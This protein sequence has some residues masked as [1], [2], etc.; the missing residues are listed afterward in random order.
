[1]A[2]AAEQ[3]DELRGAFGAAVVDG[4]GEGVAVERGEEGAAG[5]GDGGDEAAGR[6][7]GAGVAGG[8][9]AFD[10]VQV[11]FDAAHDG[12]EGDV[13]GGL[14][15]FEAAAAAAFEVDEAGLSEL[16]HDFAEVVGRDAK[17]GGDGFGGD[18]FVGECGEV[19]QHAE[20][21]VGGFGQSHGWLW[22]VGWWVVGWV[23]GR[24]MGWVMAGGIEF[25]G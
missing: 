20:R 24:V 22:G 4:I 19:E 2:L 16:V 8:V 25:N 21:V 23:V 1:M 17:R 5:F 7:D 18:A 9:E 6:D 3:L 12:A 14:S 13:G 11:G 15:E 10:D